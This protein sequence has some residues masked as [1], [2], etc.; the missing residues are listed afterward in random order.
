MLDHETGR[1]LK[2]TVKQFEI[3]AMPVI[4]I[5]IVG[6]QILCGVHVVRSGRPV[7]WLYIII[8]APVLGCLIY[9]AAEMLPELAG[10]RR[11][12][13]LKDDVK[14]LIDPDRRRRALQD[15]LDTADT[16]DNKL[17]L[18]VE[19]LE[20]GN[21]ETALPLLRSLLTGP[22]RNDP[23]L[24]YA[25]ARAQ[26]GCGDFAAATQTLEDLRAANPTFESAEAHLLYARGLEAQA[27]VAE[28][29]SEFD[30]VARYFPGVEARCRF[31][32]FLRQQGEPVLARRLFQDVVRSLDK[33]GRHFARDQREWYDLAKRN[34]G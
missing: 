29:R 26:F 24:M 11:A 20:R 34:L 6:L 15:R 33:A 23:K 3:A 12:R 30:A 18:A 21:P 14:N 27:R 13:R 1:L 4:G 9:A 22:H 8:L 28:A 16:A 10:G 31:A 19:Y 17:A 5:V 7:W 32:E 2:E 25:L